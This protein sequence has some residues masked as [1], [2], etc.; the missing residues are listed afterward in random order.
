MN[1]RISTRCWVCWCALLL[2]GAMLAFWG[3]GR[4]SL[5]YDESYSAAMAKNSLTEIVH[6]APGDVHPPLYYLALRLFSVV[7]GRSEAAL[8][9]FS[10]FGYLALA[11]LGIGPVRRIFGERGGLIFTLLA[12]ILPVNV[13][14][15]QEARSYSWTGFLIA[16]AVLYGYLAYSENRRHDWLLFGALTALSLYM[17]VYGVIA[18]VIY[19]AFLGGLILFT[20]HR[21]LK[22]Y[23][24]T[25][26]AVVLVYLP[27]L[28]VFLRQISFVSQDFWIQTP[29]TLDLLNALMY[30]FGNKWG[31]LFSFYPQISYICLIVSVVLMYKALQY[32]FRHFEREG[33][34][35]IMTALLPLL[36]SE[37]ALFV[38]I[39][40][41]RP[42]YVPRYLFTVVGVATLLLMAGI[43]ALPSRRAQIAACVVL[44]V[45]FIPEQAALKRFRLNGPMRETVAFM[46]TRVSPDD[47]F[48]HADEH[49]FGA[50]A[51][52]FPNNR[53]YLYMPTGFR[54]YATYAIFGAN[55]AFGDDYRAFVAGKQTVWLCARPAA[56][57][58]DRGFQDISEADFAL[59]SGMFQASI[60]HA[61]HLPT[62]WWTFELTQFTRNQQEA[63]AAA[64][65]PPS[66]IT[67]TLEGFKNAR[68]NAYLSVYDRDLFQLANDFVWQGKAPGAIEVAVFDRHLK[69][70]P[71]LTSEEQAFLASLYGRKAMMK[72]QI[73]VKSENREHYMLT[74]DLKWE[75][76]QRL[77]AI[78]LKTLNT[79]ITPIQGDRVA[80]AFDA[81]PYG[82]YHIV[83]FHDE[84]NN[85]MLDR[86]FPQLQEGVGVSETLGAPFSFSFQQ[87]TLLL[88][89]ET[90]MIRL[91]M[92]YP[93]RFGML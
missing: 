67:I 16:A 9:A 80:F 77:Q 21:L 58:T 79:R 60:I 93:R 73:G 33:A 76:E 35:I 42:I 74:K 61:F 69:T 45:L 54:G 15:A 53:H 56:N 4:E 28:F 86:R 40:L 44:C 26:A 25:S 78:L 24:L 23:L 59:E 65:I 52:Y 12:V 68:G 71:A 19:F 87:N 41:K 55:A 81:L 39:S 37:A 20:R 66:P 18:M 50:F 92:A 84:N 62:S 5:W 90:P 75:E 88:S 11:A 82:Y 30:P 91:H 89:S 36:T 13:S 14:M 72:M 7:F 64:N 22:A 83:A 29:T 57:Y 63:L 17:H 8:R 32:A 85:L 27:W 3:I 2:L 51:Y 49:S 46:K 47:V 38:S 70:N 43:R 48:V 10:A 1:R 34:F 6:Y 31:A